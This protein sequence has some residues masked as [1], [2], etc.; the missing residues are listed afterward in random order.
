[1]TLYTIRST[2]KSIRLILFLNFLK[3]VNFVKKRFFANFGVP[4]WRSQWAAA[5]MFQR[6]VFRQHI[7]DPIIRNVCDLNS[8]HSRQLK[9]ENLV[10]RVL[11]HF[12]F[13][14]TASKNSRIST[15]L[16]GTKYN[17]INCRTCSGIFAVLTYFRYERCSNIGQT[18]FLP[19]P[20]VKEVTAGN[21]D[22]VSTTGYTPLP[23][24]CFRSGNGLIFGERLPRLW[25]PSIS[26]LVCVRKWRKHV[27]LY[28]KTGARKPES[29]YR[30]SNFRFRPRKV[31]YK[32]HI[33]CY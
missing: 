13:S 30:I 28:Y 11:R 24:F 29:N 9:S 21:R 7:V 1:M 10:C 14:Y 15:T 5:F 17:L 33:Y 16:R 25:Y 3:S 4:Y 31:I 27:S 6:L 18:R 23:C 12:S 26:G 19:F 32:N 20:F 8:L 2:S 22:V